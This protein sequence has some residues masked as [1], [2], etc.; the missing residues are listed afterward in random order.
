MR[1]DRFFQFILGVINPYLI[2]HVSLHFIQKTGPHLG[3]SKDKA[4]RSFQ[5][6]R[7]LKVLIYCLKW[8][9]SNSDFF[10]RQR[11]KGG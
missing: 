11:F 2:E 6:L 5:L 4:L 7:Y 3:Q 9:P 8:Y 10:I 1:G